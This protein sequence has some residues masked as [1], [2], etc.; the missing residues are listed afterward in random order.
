MDRG[1]G[2][3]DTDI[4]TVMPMLKVFHGNG[5]FHMAIETYLDAGYNPKLSTLRGAALK[6]RFGGYG[7][8]S[9][10][11]D[12]EMDINGQ[13]TENKIDSINAEITV[14]ARRWMPSADGDNGK[15]PGN[16]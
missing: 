15:I 8:H 4:D 7:Q 9:I 16:T 3:D 10:Q 1:I 2:Q 12:K 14:F 11:K 13:K 5:E 6:G